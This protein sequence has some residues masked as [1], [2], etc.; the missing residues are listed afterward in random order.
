MQ[1]LMFTVLEHLD[2]FARF[3]LK[4]IKKNTNALDFVI[5][6]PN[7]CISTKSYTTARN[8][9]KAELHSGRL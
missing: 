5:L 6:F 8:R 1:S 2:S 9:R 4:T 7:E 3:T